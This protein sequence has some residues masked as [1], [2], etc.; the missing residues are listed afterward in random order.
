LADQAEN[1]SN[2]GYGNRIMTSGTDEIP[3]HTFECPT[4]DPA[5]ARV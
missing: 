1:E 5:E 3:V 4:Y 2:E